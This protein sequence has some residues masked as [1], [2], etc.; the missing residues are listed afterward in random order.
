MIGD[1]MID[2]NG[3]VSFVKTQK[4]DFPVSLPIYYCTTELAQYII[5]LDLY[6]AIPPWLMSDSNAG[7]CCGSHLL[8]IHAI[9]LRGSSFPAMACTGAREEN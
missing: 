3:L 9:F 8:I 1:K 5:L 2:Y 6:R 7:H 4:S